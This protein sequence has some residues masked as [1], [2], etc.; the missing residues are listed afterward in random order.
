MLAANASADS[1]NEEP[2]CDWS[3]TFDALAAA[4]ILEF[5]ALLR[6][7]RQSPREAIVR[8]FLLTPGR[9]QVSEQAVSVLLEPSPYHVALRV[10]GL[11]SAMDSVS[12]MANR[13]L[14][15]KL[16]GM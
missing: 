3:T 8:Q 16:L 5:G 15:F 1:I 4:L 12:W 6:G 2:S 10:S 14:E 13:R 7:F 11:D 9:I